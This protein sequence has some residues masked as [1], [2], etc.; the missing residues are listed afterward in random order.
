MST[1]KNDVQTDISPESQ[2]ASTIDVFLL[3]KH[4]LLTLE[5]H[6]N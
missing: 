2:L 1:K 3:D 4:K 5:F 6:I